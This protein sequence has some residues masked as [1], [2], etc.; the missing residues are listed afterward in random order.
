MGSRLRS[1]LALA[2]VVAF[3]G[4]AIGMAR[5]S[6][7]KTEKLVLPTV[8]GILSNALLFSFFCNSVRL[9]F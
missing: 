2:G 9:L 4:A 7:P 5:V 8:Q 1:V 6:S 3:H